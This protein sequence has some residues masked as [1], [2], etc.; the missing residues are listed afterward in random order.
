MVRVRRSGRSGPR[1]AFSRE[2]GKTVKIDLALYS[3][4]GV[5]GELG[6]LRLRRLANALMNNIE[7]NGMVFAELLVAQLKAEARG[8]AAT[9]RPLYRLA[10]AAPPGKLVQ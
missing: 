5:H 10:S 8:D 4:T 6:V 9:E 1:T 3:G 2:R 7:A